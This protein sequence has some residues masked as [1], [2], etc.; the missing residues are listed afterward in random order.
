[1]PLLARILRKVIREFRVSFYKTIS[2]AKLKGKCTL[3]SPVLSEGKGTIEVGKNSVFGFVS[4]SGFWSGYCFLNARS[5]ESKISIGED[6]HICNQ[7]SAVS[8]GPGIE[9]GNHVLIGS[10]V[11]IYDSDFHEIAPEHRV[12]G[13]PKMGKVNIGNNVWIGDRVT[14]L[15]GSSVGDN[16]VIAAGAVV[17]GV[18]PANVIIGGVPAEI[19]RQI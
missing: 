11:S 18:Y 19:I 1:M 10:Q 3:V 15:K 13:S 14:V 7:F 5:A 4:D 2:T 8:E 9:I 12:G 17:S 16:S 6:C